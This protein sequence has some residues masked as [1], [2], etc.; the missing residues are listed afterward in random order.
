MRRRLGKVWDTAWT[1]MPM[2]LPPGQSLGEALKIQRNIFIARLAIL[3]LFFGF[4]IVAM[5]LV[6]W[7]MTW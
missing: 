6:V 4:W 5:F 2:T 1:P 3:G 7:A